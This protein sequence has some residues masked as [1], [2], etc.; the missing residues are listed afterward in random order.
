M[1][2]EKKLKTSSAAHEGLP[3]TDRLVI[4]LISSNGRKN[5][6]TRSEP[7]THAMPKSDKVD[8]AA[9]VVPRHVPFTIETGSHAEKEV[10]AR[11]GSY[12]KST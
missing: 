2:I 4:N 11:V 12:E 10:A 9:K 6:V 3:A 7:M 5:E 1:P 8:F